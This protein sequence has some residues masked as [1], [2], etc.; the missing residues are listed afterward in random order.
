MK[1]LLG[2]DFSDFQLSLQGAPVS[3]LRVNTLKVS[4]EELQNKLP[5]QLEALAWS[6]AGF[7][8]KEQPEVERREMRAASETDTSA[9]GFS[10]HPTLAAHPS[11]G[12]H[13]YHAAGLYYL[14]EPSA[15]AVA[16]LLNPQPGESVLDLCAAPGGKTTHLAALMQNRGLLMA[17]EI[18]PK[19]VWELVENLERWGVQH[20][21]IL[22]EHPERLAEHFPAFFD[23]VLVDAPCSGEGMFRKSASARRD[24]SPNLVA[25]CA[26]RG[27]A[28][29]ESSARMLKPG[30]TLAYS[31]C[32]F[33][34]MENESTIARFLNDHSDFEILE[35][36]LL[37]GF[38]P[39]KPEWVKPEIRRADLAWAVRLWPHQDAGEGHFIALLRRKP[40]GRI[41]GHSPIKI[42]HL[43]RP[44]TSRIEP[45]FSAT[46]AFTAFCKENL[47]PFVHESLL[48]PSRLHLAGTFLYLIPLGLPD[49]TGLRVVRMGWW[50]GTCHP[51]QKSPYQRFEP[52]HALALG[53]PIEAA[54]RVLN[55]HADDPMVFAYL[56]GLT[57]PWQGDDGWVILAVEGHPMGWGKSSKGV[58]KN[59]YP[60]GLRWS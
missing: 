48:D 31:T 14:Q 45:V 44:S 13:P 49:M 46:Q 41:I 53:L 2:A 8:L 26:K 60:R 25:S 40:V 37:P 5:F 16:E 29:L 19:R 24:W 33:N 52:S 30:G 28:I 12:K 21:A 6:P 55:L 38:S 47:N 42:N 3:G 56:R 57:L 50:L 58:L 43:M 34:P 36:Q 59:F 15:M 17:N 1:S 9:S 54:R 11:A 39:G 7:K 22:N 32:T 27:S 23:K 51:A 35:V 4:P 10:G 18:H 20:A